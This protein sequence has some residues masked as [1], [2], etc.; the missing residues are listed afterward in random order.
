MKGGREGGENSSPNSSSTPPPPFNKSPLSGL[1]M[2][3]LGRL[4]KSALT[5][6]GASPLLETGP[7]DYQP[8]DK[9]RVWDKGI[10]ISPTLDLS[11]GNSH[12]SNCE[13]VILI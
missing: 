2:M 4:L 10:H 5:D 9:Y 1:V 11:E 8:G 3:L 7:D 6:Y 13:H 12:I